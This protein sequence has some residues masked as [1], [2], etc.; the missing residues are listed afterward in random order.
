LESF[1]FKVQSSKFGVQSL[2]FKVPGSEFKVLS[3]EFEAGVAPSNFKLETNSLL[4]TN[5]Q[6][7]IAF[8]G[9]SCNL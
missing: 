2:E 7:K 4:L 3:S 9:P 6:N 8:L 5:L 1:E